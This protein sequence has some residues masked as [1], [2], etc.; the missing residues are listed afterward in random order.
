MVELPIKGYSNKKGHTLKSQTSTHCYSKGGPYTALSQ[1]V[2][3]RSGSTVPSQMAAKHLSVLF[4]SLNL[5]AVF[6][7][8]EQAGYVEV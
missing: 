1:L 6:S 5:R 7:E 2:C 8:L 4:L 3:Y